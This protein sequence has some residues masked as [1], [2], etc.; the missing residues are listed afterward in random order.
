MLGFYIAFIQDIFFSE[1]GKTSWISLKDNLEAEKIRALV[2]VNNTVFV[3]TDTGLYRR[4]AEAWEQLSVGPADKRGQK[5][6]IHALAASERRLYVAA[7]WEFTNQIGDQFKA[8]MTGD[9][10]WSLYRS[11]DLGDTWYGIDPRKKTENEREKKGRVSFEFPLPSANS[12]P[13]DFTYSNIKIITH[14][15]KVMVA[16]PKELFYSVNAGETWTSLDLKGMSTTLTTNI[17]PPIIMLDANTFYIGTQSGVSRTA[18]AGKSW[19]LNLIRDSLMLLLW[20]Y[21]LLTE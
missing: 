5:L 20:S 21:S 4:N 7:G 12:K 3:G 14:K 11:T 6:T 2:A 16:D 1:D 15:A 9:N 8:I 10:W 13:V 17:A 19:D 18:D